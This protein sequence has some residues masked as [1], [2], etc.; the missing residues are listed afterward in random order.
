MSNFQVIEPHF[1]SFALVRHPDVEVAIFRYR[2]GVE[3][4]VVE[5]AEHF[6][7][8]GEFAVG[9]NAQGACV[10][11]LVGVVEDHVVQVGE[12]FRVVAAAIEDTGGAD[13]VLEHRG[14]GTQVIDTIRFEECSSQQRGENCLSKIS[15]V[16]RVLL[17]ARPSVDIDD[18]AGADFQCDC[19][20]NSPFN[21]SCSVGV[22][23][24]QV[25][26][27]VGVVMEERRSSTHKMLN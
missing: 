5:I 13:T 16:A 4:E 23:P 21:V 22:V 15:R 2:Y 12:W 9:V 6:L 14:D 19:G 11:E 25:S 26:R 8:W 24:V 18:V 1:R 3:L 20:T 10:L 27:T 7:A 17:V